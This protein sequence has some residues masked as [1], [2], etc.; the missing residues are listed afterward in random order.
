[1]NIYDKKLVHCKTCGKCIGE[2]DY[3]SQVCLPKCNLCVRFE[4]SDL[5][6]FYPYGDDDLKKVIISEC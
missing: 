6:E 1:M 4:K 2:I 3:D 5:L